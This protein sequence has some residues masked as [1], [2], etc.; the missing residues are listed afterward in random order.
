MY[1][2]DGDTKTCEN[3]KTRSKKN[4]V[5]TRENV[6]LCSKD[7][8]K[9]KRSVEN[10]Y[11]NLH[12]LQVFID[13]T[14]DA[15]KKLCYNHIRGCREQLDESYKFSKCEE[16]LCVERNKDHNRR[17]KI[18]IDNEILKDNSETHV[19]KGCTSCCKIYLQNN[20]RMF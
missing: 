17:N 1:Y 5:V 20:S 4:N 15:G 13:D 14:K 10:I 19:E 6:V 3:C 18:K 7:G 16:C 8:C 11:C 2:M 12:Q 9:Y